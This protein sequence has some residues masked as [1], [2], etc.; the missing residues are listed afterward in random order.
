MVKW[1]VSVSAGK[2]SQQLVDY[3]AYFYFHELIVLH[4]AIKDGRLEYV[5]IFLFS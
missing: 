1:F 3:H 5:R 2:P 4:N